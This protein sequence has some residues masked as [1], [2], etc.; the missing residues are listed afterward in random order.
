MAS[1]P[2]DYL[3][4]A[5]LARNVAKKW[6]EV[7]PNYTV[8]F[9]TQANLLVLADNFYAKALANSEHDG[10]KKQNSDALR[11]INKKITQSIAR[12]KEYI[13]DEYGEDAA[14]NYAL[15]GLEKGKG[16]NYT[17]PTDNDRRAQRLI[18]LLQKMGE[19]NNPLASKKQGLAYWTETIS[20]HSTLWEASKSMKSTKSE[21]SQACKAYHK[22]VGDLLAKLH[23]QISIDFDKSEVATT[24][25]SF[26]FLT[27][28]YK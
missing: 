22:E 4:R 9:C 16:T 15:Y 20:S 26:G 1:N 21:L 3:N 11:M 23:K 7:F 25:R 14:A 10:N 27:E 2:G 28:T 17:F 19:A 12:L 8:R 18:I 6:G 24:R 13:R 5:A